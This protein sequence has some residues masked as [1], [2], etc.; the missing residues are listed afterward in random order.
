MILNFKKGSNI[1]MVQ[2]VKINEQNPKEVVQKA[3][4][5]ANSPQAVQKPL[6]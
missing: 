6:C 5:I 3:S 4:E 2:V 1:E